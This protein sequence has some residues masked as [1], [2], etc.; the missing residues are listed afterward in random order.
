[1]FNE[2]RIQLRWVPRYLLS[3]RTPIAAALFASAAL[4][5]A[6][7]AQVAPQTS[8]WTHMSVVNG[9]NPTRI[10]YY[11]GTRDPNVIGTGGLMGFARSRPQARD[12]WTLL[13]QP[14][15]LNTFGALH[16][17]EATSDYSH[18]LIANERAYR[19]Q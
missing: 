16:C 18:V 13:A 6:G 2:A 15:Q 5:H 4:A 8:W 1:M 19:C 7:T 12:G 14:P 17:S 10:V 11:A 3:C 9:P